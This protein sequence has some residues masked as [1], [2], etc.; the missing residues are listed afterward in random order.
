MEHK[1][2]EKTAQMT[3]KCLDLT[4]FCQNCNTT[5]FLNILDYWINDKM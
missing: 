4:P 5:T 3:I 2:F 1:H